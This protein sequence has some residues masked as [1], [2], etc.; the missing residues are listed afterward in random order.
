MATDDRRIDD[1]QPTELNIVCRRCDRQATA[2]TH[3]LKARYGNPTLSEVA[4]MVAADGS[5]PCNLAG[6]EGN[7]LCG[8]RPEEPPVEQWATLLHARSG[9][10]T[11][12]LK[13]QRRHAA[14]KAA[15][16]CPGEFRIDV[17]SLLM[18]LPWDFPLER[19]RMR[20]QCPGCETKAISITWDT[21]PPEPPPDRSVR[22]RQAGAGG[23]RVIR[24]GA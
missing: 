24:G 7:A 15:K 4:F 12:W 3:A 19:L 10:W 1:Y 20:L 2:R 13:C 17:H 11:A 9:G 22:Q 6:V 8:A 5:P 23:L 16:S 21:T 18:V 14:L